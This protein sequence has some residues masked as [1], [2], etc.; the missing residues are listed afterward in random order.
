MTY[1]FIVRFEK[2]IQRTLFNDKCHEKGVSGSSILQELAGRYVMG[3]VRV[4]GKKK[5]DIGRE[6]R[7]GLDRTIS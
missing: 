7:R 2:E 4:N 5:S 1:N 6:N 3:K